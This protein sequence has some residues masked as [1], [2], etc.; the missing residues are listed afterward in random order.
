MTNRTIGVAL[1][2]DPTGLQKGFSAGSSAAQQFATETNASLGRAAAA[3]SRMVAATDQVKQSVDGVS[4]AGRAHSAA[5]DRFVRDMERQVA[6]IGKTRIEL[7]EQQAAE[8]GVGARTAPMLAQLR[9]SETGLRR[10]GMSAKETAFAL[11]GVPAQFTDIA[12][13]LATGQ[14][15]LMVMLQQ[16]GQLK[17]MFGGIGPAARALGGYVMGIVN[18]FRLAAGSAALLA[19]AYFKGQQE[20]VEF[21][22]SLILTGGYAG[23]SSGQLAVMAERIGGISGTTGKAADALAQITATGKFT[24]SSIEGIGLAAVSMNDAT[25]TAVSD[26]IAEFVRLGESPADASA[27]L[28]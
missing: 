17:D 20:S 6:A 3:S 18:P 12:V 28:N 14:R 8:L 5:A 9:A 19:T 26:T 25:G 7:L 24:G 1:T 16:G 4:L 21:N 23:Q 13:S 2:A 22:K 27:N 10:V 15:P 11:R